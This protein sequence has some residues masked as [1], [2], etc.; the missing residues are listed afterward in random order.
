M[1]RE[2]S[3]YNKKKPSMTPWGILAIVSIIGLIATA[4]SG[5]QDTF[6]VFLGGLLLSGFGV[7]IVLCIR[8]G[9]ATKRAVDK[10]TDFVYD[11]GSAFRNVA[12][13]TINRGSYDLL[14][15]T[16]GYSNIEYVIR[17]RIVPALASY[18]CK[19]A[20]IDIR[21][22]ISEVNEYSSY[23][24]STLNK[25]GADST[26]ANVYFK[27]VI[28]LVYAGTISDYELRSRLFSY[29]SES[30]SKQ[31]CVNIIIPTI[32]Y[33]TESVNGYFCSS[34]TNFFK[35]LGLSTND[36]TEGFVNGGYKET[37]MAFPSKT[38]Y[39]IADYRD[40]FDFTDSPI[41][42][43]YSLNGVYNH[44]N[45]CR[46]VPIIAYLS[47]KQGNL[48]LL[49]EDK[50]A[51]ENYIQALKNIENQFL[52]ESI[53]TFVNTTLHECSLLAI[54]KESELMSKLSDYLSSLN[55]VVL[56]EIIQY[57]F[58]FVRHINNV[59]CTFIYD[60]A[61]H[62][63]SVDEINECI[64]DAGFESFVFTPVETEEAKDD[65][66]Y[67]DVLG[68]EQGATLEEIKNAYRKLSMKFHPDKLSGKDLDEEFIK[69]AETRFREINEA[70]EVLRSK[71]DSSNGNN[72]TSEPIFSDFYGLYENDAS[73]ASHILN[74]AMQEAEENITEEEKSA[75]LVFLSKCL[76]SMEFS[77]NGRVRIRSIMPDFDSDDWENKTVEN[78]SIVSYTYNGK[79]RTFETESWGEE[80][81]EGERGIISEDYKSLTLFESEEIG[82]IKLFRVR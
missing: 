62:R 46:V 29:L 11:V 56:R 26:N 47:S 48:D 33:F 72:T 67:Y 8:A 66:Q 30:C 4:S 28:D 35:G 63:I 7:F 50:E 24:L 79:D 54:D 1:E 42:Q 64:K 51:I 38:K 20:L 77:K 78:K 61:S 70:Y 58:H 44:M 23:L 9:K 19:D 69:Y 68:L 14:D 13:N 65:S 55:T 49:G 74:I 3:D 21:K 27:E 81:S 52:N 22:N 31:E 37:V 71:F 34:L 80:E 6:G 12:T 17:V 5:D 43:L 2:N 18:L 41:D 25:N 57:C 76:L 15:F 73:L 16:K 36:I 60:I 32:L 39:T 75:L 53:E 59:A 40:L 45:Y 10:T 82:D